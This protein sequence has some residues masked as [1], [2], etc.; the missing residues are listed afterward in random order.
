MG[1]WKLI[2]FYMKHFDCSVPFKLLPNYKI[3]T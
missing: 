2:Y 3:V 1:K